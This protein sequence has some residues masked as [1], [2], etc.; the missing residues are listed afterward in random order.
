MPAHVTILADSDER[1]RETGKALAEGMFPGC[2]LE[3]H[4]R[5]EGEEPDPLFNGGHGDAALEAAAIARRI[6]GNANN[7]TQ[8]LH[9]QL[10]R[11][12][13]GAAQAR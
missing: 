13:S 1:T 12:R 11:T 8:A 2:N 4:A 9:P 5:P 6:G 10:T 3:V 7:V